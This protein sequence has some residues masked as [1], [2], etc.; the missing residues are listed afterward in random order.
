MTTRQARLGERAASPI[1]KQLETENRGDG[2]E[3]VRR[4]YGVPA[5]VGDRVRLHDGRAREG[6]IIGGSQYLHVVFDGEAR[7]SHLHPTWRVDY[8]DNLGNVTASS[9]S[10]CWACGRLL[11]TGT[12]HVVKD[13]LC[14]SLAPSDTP[15]ASDEMQN[16]RTGVA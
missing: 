1:I 7:V 4:R 5:H 16:T 13:G 15:F 10:A 12:R 2:C 8:I 6:R 3:Y 11:A 14:R 9:T